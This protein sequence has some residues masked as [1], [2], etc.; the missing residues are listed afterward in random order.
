[1]R[2]HFDTAVSCTRLGTILCLARLASAIN[3]LRE[4]ISTKSMFLSK[5][6]QRDP[7]IPTSYWTIK[8]TREWA[9]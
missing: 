5:R 6:C 8:L 7:R 3:L 9:K 2:Y 4:A 1:M